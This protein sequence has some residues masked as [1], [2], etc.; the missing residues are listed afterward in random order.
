MRA[1]A[2]ACDAPSSQSPKA[3]VLMHAV[4]GARMPVWRS[5]CSTPAGTARERPPTEER[6]PKRPRH[7][8]RFHMLLR[9][10]ER[11]L[12]TLLPKKEEQSCPFEQR[13]RI[14]RPIEAE[15]PGHAGPTARFL[16]PQT[17]DKMLRLAISKRQL[18]HGTRNDP[19]DSQFLATP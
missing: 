1:I 9:P 6:P 5:F 8:H 19:N 15:Y 14:P 18:L 11:R 3:R 2:S 13:T 4:A 12:P 17:P 10:E 16:R 7:P